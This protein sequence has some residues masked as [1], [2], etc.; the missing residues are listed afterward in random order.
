MTQ[1]LSPGLSP[2][3]AAAGKA[4]I[5]PAVAI[6][7]HLPLE[8]AR[9]RPYLGLPFGLSVWPALIYL[10]A[11]SLSHPRSLLLKSMF[12]ALIVAWFSSVYLVYRTFSPV[13]YGEPSLSVTELKDLRWKDSWNILL[14]KQ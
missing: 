1:F 9:P 14:R 6:L 13:T 3:Q 12:S 10:P 5:F 7:H 4:V 11:L 8:K 2:W